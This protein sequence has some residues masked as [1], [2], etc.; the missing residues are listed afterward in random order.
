MADE[1]DFERMRRLE[2]QDREHRQAV[3]GPWRHPHNIEWAASREIS[4]GKTLRQWCRHLED[5]LRATEAALAKRRA[6]DLHE[7]PDVVDEPHD[8]QGSEPLVIRRQRGPWHAK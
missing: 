7:Q 3:Y 4:G 6:A 5:R 2:R 8:E 1:T